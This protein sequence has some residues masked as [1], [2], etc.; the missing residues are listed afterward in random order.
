MP[1]A[2][3]S[4]DG[5]ARQTSTKKTN[6]GVYININVDACTGEWLCR[7]GC[8]QRLWFSLVTLYSVCFAAEAR[9]TTSSHLH[10]HGLASPDTQAIVV[11]QELSVA[12]LH[13]I[14]EWA[15]CGLVMTAIRQLVQLELGVPFLSGD[16]KK[17]VCRCTLTEL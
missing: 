10:N 4:I 17:K 5:R 8:C 13:S 1:R 2:V 9:V 16:N 14:Q 11:Q 6:C 3:E 15:Q 12:L 7:V